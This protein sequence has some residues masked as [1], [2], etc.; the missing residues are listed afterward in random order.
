MSYHTSSM[1]RQGSHENG[2][3]GEPVQEHIRMVQN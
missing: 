2:E 3:Y 1:C